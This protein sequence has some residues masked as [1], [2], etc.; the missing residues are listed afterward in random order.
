MHVG[1]S[2]GM[3]EGRDQGMVRLAPVRPDGRPCLL[4]HVHL[5]SRATRASSIS[6]AHFQTARFCTADHAA[7]MTCL[8]LFHTGAA[9]L[10]HTSR[11]HHS[12]DVRMTR[13][14]SSTTASRGLRLLPTPPVVTCTSSPHWWP[15]LG[16][17]ALVNTN[18]SGLHLQYETLAATYD[19]NRLNIWNIRLQHMCGTYATSRQYL[20]HTCETD[21]TF[22]TYSCYMPPKHLQHIRHPDLLL[23]HPYETLA[24][25]VRNTCKT[26]ENTNQCKHMQHPN[27]T[28]A[29]HVW[30]QMKHQDKT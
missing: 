28:L 11:A 21:E 22:W 29:T 24:I 2:Y 13:H 26:P 23:Q 15:R 8:R 6:R 19:W 18:A 4:C 25:Y 30:K 1:V 3:N 27:K 20:Q 9:C 12:H 14:T 16:H 17:T 10:F 5:D 7:R